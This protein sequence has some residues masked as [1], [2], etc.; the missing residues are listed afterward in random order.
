MT[1]VRKEIFDR[2]S[3]LVCL[4]IGIPVMVLIAALIKL[5]H[6]LLPVLFVETVM[7]REAVPFRF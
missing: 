1:P 6:P 5:E 2:V 4:I 7:G 3:A